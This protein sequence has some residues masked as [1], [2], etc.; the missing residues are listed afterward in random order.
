MG[1]GVICPEAIVFLLLEL[2]LCYWVS[3]LVKS[4]TPSNPSHICS[5]KNLDKSKP[6]VETYWFNHVFDQLFCFASPSVS[7]CFHSRCKGILGDGNKDLYVKYGI[8]GGLERKINWV[9]CLDL[10]ISCWECLLPPP[11]PLPL[12]PGGLFWR[13]EEVVVLCVCLVFPATCWK[14]EWSYR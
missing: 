9:K 10:M 3:H 2:F 1:L 14:L 5:Y 12:Q 7:G 4:D 8:W 11:P 6:T 13:T